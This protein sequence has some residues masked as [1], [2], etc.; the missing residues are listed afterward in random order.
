MKMDEVQ[1]IWYRDAKL[2]DEATLQKW[3]RH[4]EEVLV[5]IDAALE[6]AKYCP[7]DE[8]GMCD[9]N[10]NRCGLSDGCEEYR[11]MRK[12]LEDLWVG[13]KRLYDVVRLALRDKQPLAGG[14]EIRIGDK[15]VCSGV[16]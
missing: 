3:L 6:L 4:L 10:C 16:V 13:F 9:G 1:E 2:L 14:Y 5:H 8:R 12:E 15:V 11:D 7:F